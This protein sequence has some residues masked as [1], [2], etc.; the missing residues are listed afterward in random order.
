M[1]FWL[2]FVASSSGFEL[3]RRDAVAAGSSL[4][5]T[6]PVSPATAASC[7]KVVVVG[8]SGFIGSR[9]VRELVELGASVTSVSRSGTPVVGDEWSQKVSWQKGDVLSDDI[10]SLLAGS[11]AVV[12]TVG[13]LGSSDDEQA[14]GLA[15]ERLV[16]AAKKAGVKRFAYVSVF[17]LVGDVAKDVFPQYLAGKAEAEAAIRSANFAQATILKPTLVYGGAVFNINPPRVPTFWGSFVEAVLSTPPLRLLAGVSPAALKV[18]LLPPVDVDT[19]AK[20]LAQVALGS[21]SSSEFDV[22]GTDE[23]KR[24]AELAAA[25]C[26]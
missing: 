18:A 7:P 4:L 25:A 26:T 1:L 10:G 22:V 8:G 16:A 11:D 12:S 20:A 9:V 19:T 17:P 21:Y 2:A 24:V 5:L 3:S 6:K 23:I 13:A 14:N 15:N